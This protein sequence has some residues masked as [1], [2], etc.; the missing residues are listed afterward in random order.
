VQ[1]LKQIPVLILDDFGLRSYTHDEANVL[2]DILEERYRKGVVIITSQ[3]DPQGW[4][5]LFE[6][7]VIADAI[8]DR[9]TNPSRQVVLKGGSYREKLKPKGR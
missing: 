8:I 5:K 4:P 2:I 1:R 6:D 3:V 9:L 7:P